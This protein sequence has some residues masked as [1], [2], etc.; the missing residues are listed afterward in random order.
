MGW[1]EV[2]WHDQLI[3]KVRK[4]QAKEAMDRAEE[5]RESARKAARRES[6]VDDVLPSPWFASSSPSVSSSQP[7]TAR[8]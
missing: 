1:R 4:V 7:I 2:M 6:G 3:R 5:A 8:A